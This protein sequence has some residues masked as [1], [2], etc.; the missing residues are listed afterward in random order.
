MRIVRGELDTITNSVVITSQ[1]RKV[2]Q[3]LTDKMH[4][5]KTVHLPCGYLACIYNANGLLMV[6]QKFAQ[7]VPIV[8]AYIAAHGLHLHIE[9][10][11]C[12]TLRAVDGRPSRKHDTLCFGVF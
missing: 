4:N 8:D 5:V 11:H 9:C 10:K 7:L 3:L 2:T 1:L 12:A 6:N